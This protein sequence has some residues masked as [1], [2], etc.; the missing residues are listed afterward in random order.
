MTGAEFHEVDID[1]LAD[2]AGGALDGSPDEERVAALIAAEPA[3]QTAYAE[4]APAMGEVGAL[5][6]ELPPEPMPAD[7]ADRLDAALRSVDATTA[8]A[9]RGESAGVV[10]EDVVDLDLK[11]AE[12]RRW[13]RFVVPVGVAA[14]V[15][16]FA[17]WGANGLVQGQNDSAASEANTAADGSV[18]L[19]APAPERT[20]ASGTDYTLGTLAA[21]PKAAADRPFTSSEVDPSQIT[22][23]DP[24]LERLRAADALLECLDAIAGEN[25]GEQVSVESV[26]YARFDGE[27][28]LVVRFTA[29]NGGW[30][31]AVGADCGSPGADADTLGKV[32]VR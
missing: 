16:A 7:L 4:L 24:A 14:G 30:A 25:G 29:T 21:Q 32:P 27:P 23:T 12:R 10:P 6:R 8:E 13:A 31:W 17:G 11:R 18:T 26:D 20:L 9:T 15:L 19:V 3:W 2:Y 22:G 5:L 1:L 28:A